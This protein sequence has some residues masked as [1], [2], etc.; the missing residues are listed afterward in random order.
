MWES[1]T[2]FY[3]LSLGSLCDFWN[4]GEDIIVVT[5]MRVILCQVRSTPIIGLLSCWKPRYSSAIL[6]RRDVST[7]AVRRIARWPI[8]LK[9][10]GVVWFVVSAYLLSWRFLGPE[11]DRP[12]DWVGTIFVPVGVGVAALIWLWM[13]VSVDWVVSISHRSSKNHRSSMTARV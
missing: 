11:E 2:P 3:L 10:T 13:F 6:R 9:V 12:P 8:T 5:S 7:I 4:L 1:S